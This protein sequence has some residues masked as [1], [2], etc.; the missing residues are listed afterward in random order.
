[1]TENL[2][3]GECLAMGFYKPV[4]RWQVTKNSPAAASHKW[5]GEIVKG[6][7]KEKHI[8][9]RTAWR[10]HFPTCHIVR[11]NNSGQGIMSSGLDGSEQQSHAG[12]K[13]EAHK[14]GMGGTQ[15][16]W[17]G[18]AKRTKVGGESDKERETNKK[19][20]Q[21]GRW[22]LNRKKKDG[23]ATRKWEQEAH[24]LQPSE[25]DRWNYT[26]P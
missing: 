5:E 10:F 23:N 17:D 19:L 11:L 8:R 18:L 14:N 26:L 6:E 4:R 20:E 9:T 2:C 24:T 22:R 25:L 12:G 7:R 15:N 3:L 16:R 13:W 1:M 21:Q